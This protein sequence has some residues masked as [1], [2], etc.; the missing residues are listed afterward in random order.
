[1]RQPSIMARL[2]LTL[3]FA[4]LLT[5]AVLIGSSLNA[6]LPTASAMPAAKPA[7]AP[8]DTYCVA[9]ISTTY[10][11]CT[12]VF[13]NVQSAVDAGSGLETI[14]VAQGTYNTLNSRP[15]PPGYVGLSGSIN[16]V[17]YITKTVFIQGGYTTTNW[18]TPDPVAHPTTLD[19]RSLG[20][21]VLIAG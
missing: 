4:G 1:M 17:L 2:V 7:A 6:N 10:P 20:R 13:T 3:S 14:K 15:V 12:R 8:G 11:G 9:V 5:A 19:A 21:V 16:Q 18:T